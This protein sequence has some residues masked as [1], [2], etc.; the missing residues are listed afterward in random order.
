MISD[1]RPRL[2]TAWNC[3]ILLHQQNQ[4]P[5]PPTQYKKVVYNHNSQTQNWARVSYLSLAKTW[6]RKRVSETF[7]TFVGEIKTMGE[8]W[9]FLLHAL[10]LTVSLC[11]VHG[12]N[13][14]YDRTSLVINGHHKILFSGSIHYP[15]STPQV[16]SSYIYLVFFG[17]K[18]C[19][20][21]QCCMFHPCY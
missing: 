6:K 11:T 9:R 3:G 17:T 13:V 19:T 7:F 5:I 12:A 16:R 20:F 10:I 4:I 8:W 14:T 18:V 2:K 1:E 21:V 15:R